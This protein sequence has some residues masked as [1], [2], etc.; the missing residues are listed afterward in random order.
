[1]S[2][3]IITRDYWIWTKSSTHENLW[4]V[5][6]TNANKEQEE[7]C[8]NNLPVFSDLRMTPPAETPSYH[9]VA[10]YKIAP[11]YTTDSLLQYTMDGTIITSSKL[12]IS[13]KWNVWCFR[14]WFCIARLYWAG[15]NLDEFCYV[16]RAGLIIRP[17]GY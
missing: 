8:Q 15:D 9:A 17:V 16:S 6:L 11:K 14:S 7:W 12:D 5:L 13:R 4:D 2:E 1:M 10:G 3:F